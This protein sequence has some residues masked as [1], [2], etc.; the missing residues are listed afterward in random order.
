MGK[1]TEHWHPITNQSANATLK[2]EVQGWF[3]ELKNESKTEWEQSLQKFNTLNDKLAEVTESNAKLQQTLEVIK[4]N[5]K[6]ALE[7]QR[8]LFEDLIKSNLKEFVNQTVNQ[9]FQLHQAQIPNSPLCKQQRTN[10]S[11]ENSSSPDSS[12]IREIDKNCTSE[13][14]PRSWDL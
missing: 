6:Q 2:S 7:D 5:H 8:S 14:P 3:E 1:T 4:D 11:H 12:T 13:M 10:P 9:Q